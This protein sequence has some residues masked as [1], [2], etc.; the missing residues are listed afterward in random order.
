M[1]I[2]RFWLFSD[3]IDRLEAKEDMRAIRVAAS[4]LDNES[5][6]KSMQA[7]ESVVGTI[8]DMDAPPIE[9]KRDEKGIQEMKAMLLIQ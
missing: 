9:F 6:T 2:K 8:V 7:L 3:T 5:Y 4:V 1:P